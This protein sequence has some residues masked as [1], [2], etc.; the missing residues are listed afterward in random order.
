MTSVRSLFATPAERLATYFDAARPR[1][2]FED[3]DIDEV[4]LLLQQCD[5]VA[6]RCPRTYI[7]LRTI[8]H[9]EVIDRLIGEGFTDSWFP[10]E[11]RS[12]PSFLEP[13]V[14]SSIVKEQNII[15]T[16]S[17][18]LENGRHRH[19][20]PN[21]NL[22]FEIH[23][24]LGS[25]SYAQVDRIISKLSFRQ[26][27]LKRVRRKAFF[28][29]ASSREVLESFLREMRILRNLTH[30]HIVRYI[31]SYTDK[32]YLGLVMSPVADSDLAFYN[33]RLC[34]SFQKLRTSRNHIP[35]DPQ[36]QSAVTEMASN[37]R[38]FFG[39]LVSALAYLHN[40]NIRH[41][42]IKPQNILVCRGD[43]MFSDFGLS[44]DFT[45]DVGST[46]SGVTP[47]SPRYCAPEVAAYEARNTSSDIWSLG[48]VYLEMISALHGISVDDIK[49]IF[50][51]GPTTGLHY[52]NN[53]T[54][55]KHLIKGLRSE[56]GC[57][58]K[59]PLSWI[60]GMLLVDRDDRPTGARVLEM[61][62]T[63]ETTAD[64]PNTFCGICCVPG[65]E[66][67]SCDSLID[68]FNVMSAVAC[69]NSHVISIVE[70]QSRVCIKKV[71]GSE[72]H[73]HSS[74]GNNLGVTQSH[75]S[76]EPKG[77]P[78][79][80]SQRQVQVTNR[81]QSQTDAESLL[82]GQAADELTTISSVDG[83][84]KN[85]LESDQE[86]RTPRY[87]DQNKRNS[88]DSTATSGTD[89]LVRSFSQNVTT[90]VNT[91]IDPVSSLALVG[92]R[93]VASSLSNRLENAFPHMISCPCIVCFDQP[94]PE[95]LSKRVTWGEIFVLVFLTKLPPWPPSKDLSVLGLDSLSHQLEDPC[96]IL[97]SDLR[98]VRKG[99]HR[100]LKQIKAQ[101][102]SWLSE[103]P[104][105]TPDDEV[106][107]DETLT[108]SLLTR[109]EQPQRP[110]YYA[111][112]WGL[113]VIPT[114]RTQRPV[115][116]PPQY[117]TKAGLALKRLYRKH[118]ESAPRDQIVAMYLLHHPEMHSLL[119]T[120]AAVQ[121]N[122][123]EKLVAS[124][125]L[126]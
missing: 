51:E 74:H 92:S 38:T 122:E 58:D 5:H 16:K 48:C 79:T 66:S 96:Q 81:A 53:P 30:K 62:T 37:L 69:D 4:A 6:S 63:P 119:A 67:D 100:R 107:D 34:M 102:Q 31:G 33:E 64:N 19:F 71:F 76:I 13:S 126:I 86:N 111:L 98:W 3:S 57:G 44:R 24:R 115:G 32:S 29:N 125:E 65:L 7:L 108:F 89:E 52:H 118:L 27:A 104:E 43:V 109:L 82:N 99:H 10:V 70:P 77:G 36:V 50:A 1:A 46:T 42:D 78:Q 2:Q 112:F 95:E 55:T 124:N 68:D 20:A 39:C 75:N 8:G 14:K 83:N 15:L 23:G 41:K 60:A 18:D 103:I 114:P 110:L 84:Y 87:K 59:Q 54:A 105:V 85:T 22:P 90:D 93:L 117:L 120:L 121:E 116:G 35:V 28:G 72:E 26:Y 47:A 97:E 45:D 73:Q 113:D 12:L 56:E 17:L 25:G 21:E 49:R 11:H 9:L 88:R 106:I 101:V 40:Q 123:W 80:S 94:H 91:V 61:I